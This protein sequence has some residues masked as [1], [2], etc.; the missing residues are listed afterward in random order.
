MSNVTPLPR[1]FKRAFKA[2]KVSVLNSDWPTHSQRIDADVRYGLATLRARARDA[3][4]NNDHVKHFL[5]LLKTNVIGPKGIRLQ[6][7]AVLK[8]GKPDQPL[9]KAVEAGW[10]AWGRVGSAD[11]TGTLSW[12]DICCLAVETLA[13]DGEALFRLVMGWDRNVYRFALQAIDP[14]TLDVDHNADLGNGN[15]VVMGV[16]LDQWRRPV[17]YHLVK[18][19]PRLHRHD[20]YRRDRVRI[21][22]EEIIHLRLPEWVWQTRG[23]PWVHT[24]LEDAHHLDGYEEA[25]VVAAR[26]G[27]SKMGFYEREAESTPPIN[28]ATGEASGALG[29]GE[30]SQGHLVDTFEPGLT[31]ALP[32]GYTFKGWDPA[33]PNVDHGPFVKALLRSMASGFGVSYNSLANDLEGVNYSSLRQ[34]ALAERDLWMMTQELI[35]EHFCERVF[36]HWLNAALYSGALVRPNGQP[37]DPMRYDQVRAV[38]WQPRRWPWVDPQKDQAANEAALRQRTRSVSDIIRET[39]R[40]PDEVW[41]ELAQDMQRLRDLG[42]PLDLGGAQAPAQETDNAADA[43]TDNGEP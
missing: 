10:Q 42:I 33:F 11:V 36:E 7:K 9:R 1:E 22:S 24:A 14:E 34:G 16:E 8:N 6:S 30:D 39:G 2:A 3:R 17:A 21:A 20:R 25:A 35:I 28:P 32:P 23:I 40:D 37:V 4:E 43:G 38:A 15:V 41:D 18:D 5:R 29:E 12:R 19:D 31:T 13:G 26:A 27:A